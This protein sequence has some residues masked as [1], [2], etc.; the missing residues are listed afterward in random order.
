MHGH[1][2]PNLRLRAERAAAPKPA[3]VQGPRRGPYVALGDRPTY[4][5]VEGLT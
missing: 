4:P 2:T 1:E 3:R 5:S